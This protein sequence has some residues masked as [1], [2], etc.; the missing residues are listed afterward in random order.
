MTDEQIRKQVEEIHKVTAECLA[1]G[2]DACRKFLMDAGIITE[3][4]NDARHELDLDLI[5]E[6]G[7]IKD[8][9]I[10][11]ETVAHGIKIVNEMF[12]EIDRDINEMAKS[13]SSN[14]CRFCGQPCIIDGGICYDCHVFTR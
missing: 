10:S 12:S 14:K 9:A 6:F 13:Q 11:P 4:G 7:K 2:T 3:K 5:E 1:A 8:P